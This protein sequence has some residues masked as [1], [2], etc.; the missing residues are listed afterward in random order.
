MLIEQHTFPLEPAIE[1]YGAIREALR[2]LG[3]ELPEGMR[4]VTRISV[5]WMSYRN[6]YVVLHQNAEHRLFEERHADAD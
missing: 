1:N 5:E 2:P 4:D 3:V 6:P